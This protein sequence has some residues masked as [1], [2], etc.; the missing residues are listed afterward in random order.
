MTSVS[1]RAQVDRWIVS[2]DQFFGVIR[3]QA[4]RLKLGDTF[5]IGPTYQRGEHGIEKIRRGAVW[6]VKG[7]G[8]TGFHVDFMAAAMVIEAWSGKHRRCTL[9]ITGKATVES[10]NADLK[11]VL[12]AAGLT[13]LAR[14]NNIFCELEQPDARR[15]KP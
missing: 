5:E 15:E 6:H 8:N 12:A 7:Q 3:R 2:L 1:R 10:L 11:R 9:V 4:R 14:S 13:D